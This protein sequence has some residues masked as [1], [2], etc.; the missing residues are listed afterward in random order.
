MIPRTGGTGFERGKENGAIQPIAA[1]LPFQQS[2][3]GVVAIAQL[4]TGCRLDRSIRLPKHRSHLRRHS[5]VI[6]RF[7]DGLPHHFD[8]EFHQS[9]WVKIDFGSHKLKRLS[10]ICGGFRHAQVPAQQLRQ[11]RVAQGGEGAGLVWVIVHLGREPDVGVEMSLR[12]VANP[13]DL[14]AGSLAVTKLFN[15]GLH[16]VRPSALGCSQEPRSSECA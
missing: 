14:S 5:T 16:K 12:G 13:E 1:V 10:H 3:L 9:A 15:D 2:K 8:G 11:Q 4:T 6:A 7:I